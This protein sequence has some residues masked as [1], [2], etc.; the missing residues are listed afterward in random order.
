MSDLET[1]NGI[2]PTAILITIVI[3]TTGITFSL[4]PVPS[5]VRNFMLLI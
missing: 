3:T 4:D 2:D 1:G 5:Y